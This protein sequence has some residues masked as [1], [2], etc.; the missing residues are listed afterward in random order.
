MTALYHKQ[1]KAVTS[2]LFQEEAL[3]APV[4]RGEEMG[5]VATESTP[6]SRE[7]PEVTAHWCVMS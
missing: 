2:G 5:H 1:S 7:N 3:A 4:S 6:S